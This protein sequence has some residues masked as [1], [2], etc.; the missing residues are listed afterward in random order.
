MKRLLS[1][2][3]AILIAHLGLKV[4]LHQRI[5]SELDDFIKTARP[6]AK[7]EYS[8]VSTSFL[9][10]SF[11]V[12]DIEIQPMMSNSPI[13]IDKISIFG[14]DF[15]SNAKDWFNSVNF[16]TAQHQGIQV[17][18]LEIEINDEL[19]MGPMTKGTSQGQQIKLLQ[20]LGYKVLA[21][22]LQ[23]SLKTYPDT[24]YIEITY[25]QAHKGMFDFSFGA[26]LSG[27]DLGSG[28][29]NPY[30]AQS[31][32]VIDAN[33]NFTD[34]SFLEKT[35]KYYAEKEGKTLEEYKDDIMQQF[36]NE[37]EAK[38]VVVP[39]P[40]IEAFKKLIYDYKPIHITIAPSNPMGLDSFSHLHLYNPEDVTKMLNL[41]VSN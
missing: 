3:I 13:V 28:P 8:K 18:G 33:F 24:K 41:K 19:V 20:D 12:E 32:K 26:T 38:Q 5:S 17:K 39:E 30:M 15:W 34:A 37:M 9:T 2:A 31:V 29:V 36:L 1:F 6:F 21:T 11:A 10:K 25:E 7:I 27:E 16:D 23:F 35:L 40:Y 14:A 22:D 4:Y